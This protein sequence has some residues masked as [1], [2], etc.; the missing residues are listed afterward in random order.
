[1]LHFPL[2]DRLV[3]VEKLVRAAKSGVGRVW[4]FKYCVSSNYPTPGGEGFRGYL[5][6]LCQMGEV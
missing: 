1:M 3:G 6:G 4:V 5:A 2:P